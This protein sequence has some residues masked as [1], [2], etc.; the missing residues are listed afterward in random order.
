MDVEEGEA[1]RWAEGGTPVSDVAVDAQARTVAMIGLLILHEE[2][3]MV[4]HYER[5]PARVDGQPGLR[6]YRG[7]WEPD[8]PVVF[9]AP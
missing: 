2:E 5:R 1:D 6:G 9:R 3:Q 4:L 7:R 8:R